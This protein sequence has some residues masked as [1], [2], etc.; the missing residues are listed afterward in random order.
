MFIVRALFMLTFVLIGIDFDFKR[1]K[2]RARKKRGEW[3]LRYSSSVSI[4]QGSARSKQRPCA[5]RNGDSILQW[6][7]LYLAKPS[8][9]CRGNGRPQ[10]LCYNKELNLWYASRVAS[11]EVDI[12]AA[13]LSIAV[14]SH[15]IQ[16][17]LNYVAKQL[18]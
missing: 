6:V 4:Q 18:R 3:R 10:L 2:D 13:R 1:R 9:C 8:P 17:I 14:S 11:W 12:D 5:I 7:T 15:Y 16:Q